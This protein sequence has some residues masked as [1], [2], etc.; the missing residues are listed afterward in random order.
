MHIPRFVDIS[1]NMVQ[2]INVWV[3]ICAVQLPSK[4]R[5]GVRPLFASCLELLSHKQ[6]YTPEQA[7]P[8]IIAVGVVCIPPGRTSP[9]SFLIAES[10]VPAEDFQFRVRNSLRASKGRIC[11]KRFPC[12]CSPHPAFGR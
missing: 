10:L 1:G 6:T 4:E 11:W 2:V 9:N 3:E 12:K 7:H 5:G 8:A